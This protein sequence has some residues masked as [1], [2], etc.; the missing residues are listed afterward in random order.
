MR[1]IIIVLALLASSCVTARVQ[2]EALLPA[3]EQ[4]WPG[5]RDDA[6]VG[7]MDENLLLAWDRA[8]ETHDYAA[9]DVVDLEAWAIRG[10]DTRLVLGEIGVNGAGIMRSRAASFRAAVEEYLAP[11][12]ASVSTRDYRQRPLVISRSS[13]ATS[14]PPAIAGRTYR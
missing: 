13:W 2:N 3:I 1:N 10:I 12:L 4:A 14:P 9:H 6:A 8:V 7:G 5:V 11:T